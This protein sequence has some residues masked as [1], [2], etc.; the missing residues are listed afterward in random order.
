MTCAGPMT[1]RGGAA[2]IAATT[3]LMACA[4]AVRAQEA[5]TELPPEDPWTFV[6]APY[7]WAISLDGD[8]KLGGLEA[9]VD[10]PFSDTVKDLSIG[11]MLLVEARRGRFGIGVNGVFAR[12]SPEDDVGPFELDVTSDLAQLG[13]GPYWRALE[14]QYGEGAS[15]RPL[16]LVLEPTVGVRLNHLRLELD[17]SGGRQ[18]DDSETWVDPIVGTQVRARSGRALVHHGGGGRRRRRRRLGSVVERPGLPRLPHER[19]RPA[20]DLGARLPRGLRRLRPQ[21]VR[22]GRHPA[23]PDPGRGAAVL[24]PM[25]GCRRSST[26]EANEDECTVPLGAFA[27]RVVDLAGQKVSF[28]GGPHLWAITPVTTPDWGPALNVTLLFP[29]YP[30]AARRPTEHKRQNI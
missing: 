12:V 23:R 11:A 4:G 20:D 27:S 29:K 25:H 30:T 10:V 9:D 18:V 2:A 17:L 14:W 1:A 5:A 13:I 7:L 3:L 21:R 22:M 15:G 24:R 16:R 28:K 19:V 26:G 8:A 6:V